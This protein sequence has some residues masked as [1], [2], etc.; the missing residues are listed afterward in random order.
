MKRV[1]AASFL[2]L[3][4]LLITAILYWPGWGMGDQSNEGSP[5]GRGLPMLG[6]GQ[7]SPGRAPQ[8]E[9]PSATSGEK[10]KQQTAD[11]KLDP[12]AM[13]RKPFILVSPAQLTNEAPLS[14]EGH[15]FPVSD[16]VTLSIAPQGGGDANKLGLAQ[17]DEHGNF[18]GFTKPVPKGLS[19]GRYS[20]QAVSKAT[21]E[22]AQAEFVLAANSPFVV[23]DTYAAKANS[24][25][26]FKGGGFKPGEKVLFYFDA[27][28]TD[29]LG[30]GQADQYGN[31]VVTGFAVP[32]GSDGDHAFLFVGATGQSPI[33]VPFTIIGFHPWVV[34]GSYSPQPQQ[35][36]GFSGQDFFP[37][38]E[39]LVYF[40]QV[41]GRPV[42][43]LQ[44]DAKGAFDLKSAFT[45]PV[46]AAGK[47]TLIFIGR[48]T[49]IE[50]TVAF[51]ILPLTPGLE[52]TVYAGLPGTRIAFKGS[53]FARGETVHAYLG[54]G[55]NGKE[56]AFMQTDD[57]G[58]FESAGEFTLPLDTPAG[59]LTVTAQGELS[60]APVSL[61]FTVL[62]FQ[63]WGGTDHKYTVEGTKLTFKGGGFA[64]GETVNITLEGSGQTVA[65]ATTDKEGEFESAGQYLIPAQATAEMTFI[66]EGQSSKVPAKVRFSPWEATGRQMP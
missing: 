8:G 35:N 53:G 57:N 11:S 21:G 13:S 25:I 54:E 6:Q 48:Q 44:A 4:G 61:T 12:A 46:D 36:I 26:T 62:A 10:G 9:A 30:S 32:F 66:F 51:E 5:L 1:V 64:S 28:S 18:F 31:L 7:P 47:N 33:R 15:Q 55:T 29:P 2:L 17:A 43:L 37:G 60:K 14:I 3:T 50:V 65:T 58:A 27:I 16:T 56:V 41:A 63:P 45:I 23:P 52:L 24:T 39:I 20:V 22:A 40:N 38:E 34:L 49:Q 59:D 19:P 42:S